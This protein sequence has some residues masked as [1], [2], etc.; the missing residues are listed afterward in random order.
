MPTYKKYAGV[1]GVVIEHGVSIHDTTETVE[2]E[3]VLTETRLPYSSA[4]G[5]FIIGETIT[6]T[7][8][9]STGEIL[10]D[11]GS[12]FGL[13]NCS[14]AFTGGKT[15]TG[16]TSTETATGGT[17]QNLLTKT[18]D[19][20]IY[21][22]L[23]HATTVTASAPGNE[24]ISLDGKTIWVVLTAIQTATITVHNFAD[25]NTVEVLKPGSSWSMKVDKKVAKF[26]LGFSAAG[27]CLVKEFETDTNPL[28]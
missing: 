2:T 3:K 20:P 27:S 7:D 8:S 4:S 6:E 17:A 25:G 23:L 15:V 9:G 19:T 24:T 26:V 5:D 18:A 10:W 22:P 28:A 16:G 11:D 1:T 13:R 14:A 21:D 12:T